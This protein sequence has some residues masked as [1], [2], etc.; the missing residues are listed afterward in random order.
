MEFVLNRTFRHAAYSCA[1]SQDQT[2]IA[3]AS[4]RK[5]FIYS[6]PAFSQVGS[7]VIQNPASMVFLSD[8]RSLLVTN[9]TGSIYLWD[10]M[11]IEALGKW[12]TKH[13][14]SEELCYISDD[15]I[16]V[17]GPG[18][19]W[20]Y[21]ILQRKFKHL[22]STEKTAVI[23]KR[24]QEY[25]GLILFSWQDR[26]KIDIVKLSYHGE[27]ISHSRSDRELLTR[28]IYRPVGL[29]EEIVLSAV[30]PPEFVE[31]PG[32]VSVTYGFDANGRAQILEEVRS[33]NSEP[34]T[35][36]RS[37]LYRLNEDGSVLAQREAAGSN[38][39][40]GDLYPCNQ[41]VALICNA[42][43][44]ILFLD[45]YDLH[46][47]YVLEKDT[48]FPKPEINPFEFVHWIGND[49]LIVGTWERLYIL[50]ETRKDHSV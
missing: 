2:R 31:Q 1:V 16:L 49:M 46:P 15:C 29:G 34:A 45:T 10:G 41:G 43:N 7:F 40:S 28:M 9:T 38:E 21:S 35:P 33:P 8:N 39:L 20:Q 14:N 25:I 23:C 24:A 42:N 47:V 48:L 17:A 50:Q 18:G 12:P 36:P 19:V 13:Y 4:R 5:V 3:I 30:A 37:M 44:N 11:G 32:I 26:Q 22:F 6:V 27:V